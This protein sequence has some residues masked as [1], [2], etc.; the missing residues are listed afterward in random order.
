MTPPAGSARTQPLKPTFFISPAVVLLAAGLWLGGQRHTISGLEKESAALRKQIAARSLPT[1]DPSL[2]KANAPAKAAKSK[3]PLDWKKI[4]AEFADRQGG[5]RRTMMRLQQRLQAMSTEELVASLDEIAAL[6]LPSESRSRLE[7]MLLGPLSD[8]NPEL[9]LTKFIGRLETDQ[10]M[11]TWQLSAALRKWLEKDP[12]KA[13]AWFDREI[14]AGT[15]EAKALNG[16]SHSRIQFEGAAVAFLLNSDAAAAARRLGALPADQRDDVLSLPS[17]QQLKEEDQ[18]AFAKLV[19]GQ[20]SEDGQ[21]KALAR[22]VGRL[23]GEDSYSK[24]ADFM[25]RIEATP[26]E[27]KACVEEVAESMTQSFSNQKPMTR[28]DFDRLRGWV[29]E[30]DPGSLGVVTGRTLATASQNGR[31]D[32]PEAAELAMQYHAAAGNDDVLGAFLES[33]AARWNKDDARPLVE[34]ISDP[35]RRE[36][37][38]KRLK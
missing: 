21:A 23:G 37:I 38:L 14:G 19:R 20:I 30:Q 11:M 16:R 13:T 6:D 7:Q 31:I 26:A 36:E 22:Q 4:A 2:A 35:A 1:A 8:K 15:F 33:D 9:A 25:K 27:R 18:V 34:K 10:G 17:F 5:D 28:E 12:A 29:G 3:K 24:A 32:F